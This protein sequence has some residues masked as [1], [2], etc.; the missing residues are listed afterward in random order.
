MFFGGVPD[1]LEWLSKKQSLVFFFKRGLSDEF[2]LSMRF[3]QVSAWVASSGCT[4]SCPAYP[5]AID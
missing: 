1:S 4:E 2:F 3:I 5:Q